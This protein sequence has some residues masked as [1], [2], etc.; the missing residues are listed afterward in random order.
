MFLMFAI[1]CI[2][3]VHSNDAKLVISRACMEP[4]HCED[5]VGMLETQTRNS[6]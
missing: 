1:M 3:H 6:D 5:A 4:S 2:P